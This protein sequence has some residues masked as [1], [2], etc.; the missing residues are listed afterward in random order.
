[1]GA[2][3]NTSQTTPRQICDIRVLCTLMSETFCG[4]RVL[5]TLMSETRWGIRVLCTLMSQSW[6]RGST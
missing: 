1:M 5:C 2:Q 4:I 3:G 6:R